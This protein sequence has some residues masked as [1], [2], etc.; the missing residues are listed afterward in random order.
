M[1]FDHG[2]ATQKR[3]GR[4][5][6]RGPWLV[7][8]QGCRDARPAPPTPPRCI[9]TRSRR[10]RTKDGGSGHHWTTCRAWDRLRMWETPIH[11]WS[12]V[13]RGHHSS[14]CRASGRGLPGRAAWSLGGRTTVSSLGFGGERGGHC[15]PIEGR[16]GLFVQ[17]WGAWL[18]NWGSLGARILRDWRFPLS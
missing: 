5:L 14:R 9:P 13:S 12:R 7:Q 11:T 17:G 18:S 6:H 15:G 2:W 10:P 4:E 16:L 8:R 3:E 1:L